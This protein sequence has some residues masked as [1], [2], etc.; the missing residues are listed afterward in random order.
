MPP[1]ASATHGPGAERFAGTPRVALAGIEVSPH[2]PGTLFAGFIGGGLWRS[3]DRGG[4]WRKLYPTSGVPFNASAIAVDQD[5]SRRIAAACEPL[6]WAPAP[7]AVVLSGDGGESFV[8]ITPREYGALRWKGLAFARCTA[9]AP[10]LV[11]VTCGNGVLAC[12]LRS[13]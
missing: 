3:D 10:E 5:D 4:S 2:E 1:A 8:E 6:Y 7:S 12:G 9:D 11:G 13:S